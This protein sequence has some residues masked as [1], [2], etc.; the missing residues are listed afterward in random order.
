MEKGEGLDERHAWKTHGGVSDVLG[1]FVLRDAERIPGLINTEGFERLFRSGYGLEMAVEE[2][3]EEKY[4]KG[5]GKKLRTKWHLLAEYH[6]TEGG[7]TTRPDEVDDEATGKL[8][9]EALLQKWLQKAAP[10]QRRR[11]TNEGEKSVAVG[12][13]SL[14]VMM[15]SG[16]RAIKKGVGRSIIIILFVCSGPAAA[17]TRGL[18]DSGPAGCIHCLLPLPHSGSPWLVLRLRKSR[19]PPRHWWSQE[20]RGHV[21][22]L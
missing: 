5:S 4:W 22:L 15:K 10:E 16:R 12:G 18:G 3:E 6:E 21:P 9:K 2:V 14:Y 13:R 7:R 11:R 1:A 20:R 8:K 17:W 19:L